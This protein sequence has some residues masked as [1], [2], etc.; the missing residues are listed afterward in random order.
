MIHQAILPD[1]GAKI[2]LPDWVLALQA[3]NDGLGI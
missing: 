1:D 3:L 2:T